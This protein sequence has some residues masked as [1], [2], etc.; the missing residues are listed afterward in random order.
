M[1]TRGHLVTS[2]PFG[3]PL[4][5]DLGSARGWGRPRAWTE[6]DGWTGL[7]DASI[8]SA[9][10]PTQPHHQAFTIQHPPTLRQNPSRTLAMWRQRVAQLVR[11]SLPATVHT[12]SSSTTAVT[13]ARRLSTAPPPG[14]EAPLYKYLTP[15]SLLQGVPAP[16]ERALS[17][18][19]ADAAERKQAEK[20]QGIQQFGLR[21]GD[22]GSTPVQV[23]CLTV[24]IQHVKE[25][26]AANKQDKAAR[27]GYTALLTRRR[28]LLQYL[29]RKDFAAYQN[30]IKTLDLQGFT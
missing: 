6:L 22:T 23:A 10:S 17:V 14:G 4:H 1:Q 28:K 5:E 16:V 11:Q 18:E 21:P 9:K 13:Q 25:H 27:R 24:R 30:T 8:S 20:Q 7:H 29:R 26:C 12:S 15:A 3:L 2:L 19:N